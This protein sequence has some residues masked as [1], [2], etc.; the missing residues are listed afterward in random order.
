MTNQCAG[1]HPLIRY[2]TIAEN[3]MIKIALK[4]WIYEKCIDVLFKTINNN[5]LL[6]HKVNEFKVGDKFEYIVIKDSNPGYLIRMYD[7]TITENMG[8]RLFIEI[9]AYRRI[10]LDGHYYASRM[11]TRPTVGFQ[12]IDDIVNYNRK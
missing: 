5:F 12:N 7:C 9:S 3:N 6:G 4:H 1:P 2:L 10:S 8:R 11:Q